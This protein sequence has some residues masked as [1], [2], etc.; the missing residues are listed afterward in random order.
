[1]KFK[2]AYC[3]QRDN[4]ITGPHNHVCQICGG[5]AYRGWYTEPRCEGCWK[6]EQLTPFDLILME[7]DLAMDIVLLNTQSAIKRILVEDATRCYLMVG[8]P[9]GYSAVHI[10]GGTWVNADY[11]MRLT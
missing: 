7:M 8:V 1:M 10:G 3:E 11:K 6:A 4:F 2:C 9:I 5:V